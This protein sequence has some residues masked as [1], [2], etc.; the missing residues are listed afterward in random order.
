[1]GIFIILAFIF[2]TFALLAPPT[3][4]VHCSWS[5]ANIF[6]IITRNFL[7]GLN[8][9]RGLY[10][11]FLYVFLLFYNTARTLFI[12]PSRA[13][14]I[15]KVA[16]QKSFFNKKKSL[17]KAKCAGEILFL[18][19]FYKRSTR[20]LSGACFYNLKIIPDHRPKKMLF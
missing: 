10:F 15:H 6:R 14:K 20:N 5:R 13:Y 7:S 3:R 18:R 19:E 12:L 16:S 4:T 11:R 8:L 9:P 17:H 1:M 2:S